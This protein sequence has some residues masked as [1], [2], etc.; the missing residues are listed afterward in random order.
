MVWT[1]EVIAPILLRCIN[2]RRLP[3]R[4]QLPNLRRDVARVLYLVFWCLNV[5]LRY[6]EILLKDKKTSVI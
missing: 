5:L 6:S 2:M 3:A 1:C 4:L